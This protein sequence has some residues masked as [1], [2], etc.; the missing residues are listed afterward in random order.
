MGQT[1]QGVRELDEAYEMMMEFETSRLNLSHIDILEYERRLKRYAIPENNGKI[2][3]DQLLAGF[4]G[5]EV[6]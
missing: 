4:E 5:T 1:C 2:S 6:F 3:V